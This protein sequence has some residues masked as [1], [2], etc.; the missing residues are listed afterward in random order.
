LLIN[1]K[2]HLAVVAIVSAAALAGIGQANAAPWNGA[3]GASGVCPNVFGADGGN[4]FGSGSA[5]DCNLFVTFNANGSI[6]TTNGPQISYEG[7]EDALIGVVNKTASTI[8]SFNISAP[9]IFGFE[10]DGIE[11]YV[12]NHL[13]LVPG[14]PDASGY[15]GPQAYFTNIQG[16]TGTVNFVGGIP[17]G[18]T[19][20]FS[21]EEPIDINAPPVITTAAPEP[22]SLALLGAG[23]AGL[24]FARRRR[25]LA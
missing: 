22:A 9:N 21:L 23:L 7:V 10:G 3:F 25:K 8:S 20:F 18:G 2:H 5:T 19:A 14:N 13:P 24:G 4:G 17:A 11:T 15:G 6:T 1:I 12:G 16:N